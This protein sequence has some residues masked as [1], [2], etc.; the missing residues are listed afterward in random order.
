MTNFIKTTILIVLLSVSALKTNATIYIVGGDPFGGWDPSQG[1]EMT[2][3]YD[4]TYTYST[5]IS[6][7]VYFVF[8]DGLSYDQDWEEFSYYRYSPTNSDQSVTVGSWV[9]TQKPGYGNV[10][11][12]YSFSG[13]GEVYTFTF[14]ENNSRF[15]IEGDN[16]N[17][18]PVDNRE[19]YILGE[20]NGNGWAADAGVMMSSNDNI[21]FDATVT[22]LGEIIE[23]D[24]IG[25][26]YFSFTTKLGNYPEDWD[27]IDPYRL[28]SAT[29]SDYWVTEYDMG[30]PLGLMYGGGG[31]NAFKVPAGIYHLSVNLDELTLVVN[32]VNGVLSVC[33]PDN[34]NMEEFADMSLE[35]SNIANGQT[36]RLTVTDKTNY[37][38]TGLDNNSLWNVSLI[39]RYGD[40][41]G[42]IENV[43]ST[44][45]V[46]FGSIIKPQKVSLTIRD[47]QGKDVTNLTRISWLNEN[48]ELIAQGNQ[49]IGLPAD[50]KLTYQVVLPPELAINYSLPSD[51][52]YTVKDGTNKIVCQLTSIPQVH[53]S[54]KVIDANTKLPIF[55]AR[56]SAT[57]SF[58]GDVSN[59]LISQSDKHGDYSLEAKSTPTVLTVA[60]QG[61]INQTL[62]CNT[63]TGGSNIIMSDVELRPITGTVVNVNLTYTLAHAQ[64]E[65]AETQSLYSDYNNVD[66][67]IY[68]KSAGHPITNISV[69]YPQIV[70]IE[71]VDD[72]DVLEITANSRKNAFM[73]VKTTAIVAEQRA[74]AT[75]DIK[76]LGRI[77]ASFK[78]NGNPAVVGSLY[79]AENKLIT[80]V[81]YSGSS[82]TI[83]NLADGNYKLVTMGKSEFFNSIYD[84]GQMADAGL[85]AGVDYVVR[86]VNVQSGII[87]KVTISEVPFFDE[88]KFYYT[89]DNTSFR[90]DKSK[91]VIGKYL[92]F[93]CLLDFKEQFQNSGGVNNVNLIIDL[94]KS[95]SL[96]DN[97]LLIGSIVGSYSMNDNRIVIPLINYSSL[98]RF[99]AIPTEVGD[100]APSAFVQFEYK[101]K[102]I[103]QPIGSANFLVTDLSINIPSW[104][105]KTVIP[106]TGETIG[107][108]SID[109]YDNDVLI[110]HTE[111][112]E[113]GNWTALC[114]LNNPFN[115][116]THEIYSKVTTADG[117]EFNTE[118]KTCI[119]DVNSIQVSKV[120]MIYRGEN[121]VFDFLNPSNSTGNYYSYLPTDK[122][123][124]FIIDFT[125]ND[126]S[127]VSDVLL[128]VKTSDN[129]ST[130]LTTVFDESKGCWVASKQFENSALPVNVAVGYSCNTD[131]VFDADV[132]SNEILRFSNFQN[133]LIASNQEFDSL[134]DQYYIAEDSQEGL[135][136]EA[137][138]EQMYSS[139]GLGGILNIEDYN[140]E[141]LQQYIN[142]AVALSDT[143][144]FVCDFI[145]N[146]TV[147]DEIASEYMDYCRIEHASEYTA[148]QLIENGFEAVQKTDGTYFYIWQNDSCMKFVDF[149]TDI[150]LTYDQYDLIQSLNTRSEEDWLRRIEIIKNTIIEAYQ[151]IIDKYN[152]IKS[153]LEAKANFLQIQHELLA[154]EY[155][156]LRQMGY[157][158]NWP[159]M[160]NLRAQRVYYLECHKLFSHID[161]FIKKYIEPLAK[162]K[163]I[164]I[165]GKTLSFVNLVQNAWDAF[166]NIKDL[167]KL[168]KS[169][170]S[171]CDDANEATQELQEKISNWMQASIG[172]YLI[173][174]SADLGGLI[175]VSG[176][177]A[178]L[179]PSGGTSA[180]A[181]VVSLTGMAANILVKSFY[182][183]RH[184]VNY[185]Y[186]VN[187]KNEL[188]KL[189]KE[190]EPELEPDEY[191]DY[192]GPDKT[193]VIDPSGFVYEGVP[194]NRLEGVTATCFYK[195]T[196]E[197]MYGDLQENVV[198]WDATQYG[199][200]N[201]LLTDENGYYR[202]D[203]P[204]GMW[205]VK[206]EKEGYETTYSDWLPVPPPQLDLNI[207]MVQMRQPEVIKAHAY[208]KAVELEF[209]KFMLPETLTP[210][211]IT[212]T[213]NG[214]AVNGTIEILNAELDDPSAITSIRRAP[215][216]GLTYASHVRFNAAQPF[217]ADIV[218]LHVN[219][220]VESYAGVQMNDDYE[221]LLNVE[222]EMQEIVADSVVIL[223]FKDSKQITITVLPAV[224]S[225]GK[226]INVIST[227]PMITSINAGQY[228]LDA[229]GK[230]VVTVRG[231]LPG[232][233]SLLFGIDG[234][235]L[236]ATTL[237]NVLMESQ[238]SVAT[239]TASIASGSEVEKGTAV[240]LRCATD[241][242]T[243]YYTLD[244]SC[245]CDNTPARK[246]YDGNP[247]IINSTV[248]IKAMATAPDLYDSDVATFVY[249]VG[250]GLT[251]DVNADGEVNVADINAC[252]DII[253]GGDANS[254]IRARAD[255]NGDAEINVADINAI[256]DIILGAHH[257]MKHSINCDDLLHVD[258]VTMKP[259]DV[260]AL[261]V[262]LDNAN[263]YSGLQFDI[264]L[265]AGLTLVGVSSIDGHISRVDG[266]DEVLSRAVSYSMNKRPFVGDTQPV[267]TFIVRSDAAL[268]PENEIMLTDVI[269][270]DA[271]NRAWYPGDCAVRVNNASGINDLTVGSDRVWL[272]GKTLC[273]EARQD[274]IARITAING[275][276]Y[277]INVKTGINRRVLDQG[278]Y[279][280]VINGK[281]F[282]IAVK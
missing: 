239:P 10:G 264:V 48:D 246:V 82:L 37:K 259:G 253:L 213:V 138:I 11:Y 68:N 195:E 51:L 38:F 178:A 128:N 69:Q 91:T 244:G 237:V 169:I 207:G 214:T 35:L 71:D 111:S 110:G 177:I 230:A 268:A 236:S 163:G 218:K 270:A 41:L 66:F 87:S 105:S 65:A 57:Q 220:E 201:P 24:G 166:N 240:Y 188:Y 118:V 191:E 73:P 77:E 242:A 72:G 16:S 94:P 255:V 225:R 215:G 204:I 260:R 223:P 18:N 234:Y 180:S 17:P 144:Q 192:K 60:A 29:G 183:W 208:P 241:G 228:T 243:I 263:R 142:E 205:Q 31:Y 274:G 78:K 193:A 107:K 26:S 100:F 231:D 92:T 52:T 84:M 3:N 229:N 9:K 122:N 152:N 42:I 154:K 247:V 147:F 120:T 219:Y 88:S 137:L 76:E 266:I 99:C 198:L 5:T 89:G 217:N 282:K 123:F 158:V 159:T 7:T 19:L 156:E 131:L 83:D 170:L 212:V 63:Q 262:M 233:G 164:K 145:Q 127:K 30:Q 146:L 196:V 115:L 43:P 276:V 2:N 280:V 70:L 210:N 34:V 55:D 33:F 267:L 199:Q 182:D 258:D 104:T 151:T 275:V 235:D 140:E 186:Y 6:G 202:W 272:E 129:K 58:V 277:D 252:I 108:C 44:G 206:Y 143:L 103:T 97:S 49:I 61:Y 114:E 67:E 22:T 161:R 109:I 116:S 211:N 86:T 222:L 174:L 46:T 32:E 96:I 157:D 203:V 135:I 173:Q 149:A 133:E 172:L 13:T 136:A 124:T 238:M 273:I 153:I 148:E 23:S 179:L 132:M 81:D 106:V 45:S 113:D 221:A 227:A 165:A 224:A 130:R 90:A 181:I 226:V 4:G 74:A 126:T 245:P 261:N 249:R 256:I 139:L 56:I 8:A 269:L 197:D 79:D 189:C 278:I 112:L 167:Y 28:G 85:Q 216:T 248:T 40:V 50:R 171:P 25:Y 175:G 39:N 184:K 36:I 95:C 125:E 162:S 15:K 101:G 53:I 250:N 102:T 20:V 121:L 59:T 75:F 209:D 80:I 98:V 279:V 47:P 1:V 200:E 134:V 185:K 12:A 155:N 194:S 64:G 265:P 160:K 190:P 62:D 168:K 21:V 176:G 141:E 232:M 254:D 150:C 251:G 14:D 281:S 119:Y 257:S 54:G 187:R 27:V 271:D 93:R 117:A